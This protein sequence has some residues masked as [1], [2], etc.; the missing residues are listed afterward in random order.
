M[1]FLRKRKRTWMKASEFVASLT[2]SLCDTPDTDD[3]S[4]DAGRYLCCTMQATPGSYDSVV[5]LCDRGEFEAQVYEFL[6]GSTALQFWV[7]EDSCII[8]EVWSEGGV[9][10]AGVWQ[11]SWLESQQRYTL[12]TICST[13]MDISQPAERPN[14]DRGAEAG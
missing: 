4:L 3:A 12:R 6:P 9:I 8:A 10:A 7:G 13:E 2:A 11:V 14:P 1:Q 5:V